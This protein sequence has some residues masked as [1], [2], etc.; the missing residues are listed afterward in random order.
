MI[1]SEEARAARG[2][3]RFVQRLPKRTT[4]LVQIIYES[5]NLAWSVVNLVSD[6]WSAA[7]MVLYSVHVHLFIGG[8]LMPLIYGL[9]QAQTYFIVL[10]PALLQSAVILYLRMIQSQ[11]QDQ[12]LQ[13]SIFISR[14]TST[15]LDSVSVKSILKVFF[16]YYSFNPN[17][18]WRTSILI[19]ES[20]LRCG[21][22]AAMSWM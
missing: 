3:Q 20:I 10:V 18:K 12:S 5:K 16:Y 8:L 11:R 19:H 14:P 4:L 15:S 17:L 6:S 9:H 21:V 7:F 22:D 2:Q 13:Y 1:H